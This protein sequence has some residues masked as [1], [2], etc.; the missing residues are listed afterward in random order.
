MH[1]RVHR[2]DRRSGV[3]AVI[4]SFALVASS[5]SLALM[6]L[7]LSMGP[8]GA[9]LMT[10]PA[11]A[12]GE[13]GSSGG[14]GKGTGGAPGLLKNEKF[15]GAEDS[16]DEATE[17]VATE[18]ESGGSS[19]PPTPGQGASTPRVIKEIAGVP[20]ETELSSEEELEAIRN[21][22]GTWRTADGPESVV[23]Q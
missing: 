22:W 19:L 23:A 3:A 12:G 21:G 8:D 2:K 15:L 20:G 17:S 16:A 4:R 6:A 14:T 5:G 11:F 13:T 9:L 10:A 1:S 18:S 7:A